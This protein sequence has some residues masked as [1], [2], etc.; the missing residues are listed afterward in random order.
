MLAEALQDDLTCDGS[1]VTNAAKDKHIKHFGTYP[2][3]LVKLSHT[4]FRTTHG[5]V[6][7]Y[8]AC[9]CVAAISFQPFGASARQ[10]AGG[11]IFPRPRGGRRVHSAS[12]SVYFARLRAPQCRGY[13]GRRAYNPR[14]SLVLRDR[15]FGGSTLQNVTILFT[16]CGIVL[17][18]PLFALACAGARLGA[19]GDRPQDSRGH[20]RNH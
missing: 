19:T 2:P 11:Q 18:S 1:C 9:V 20:N 15:R 8:N 16:S 3:Q 10:T 13:F 5:N 12:P 17:S 7:Y 4:A 14:P 6:T